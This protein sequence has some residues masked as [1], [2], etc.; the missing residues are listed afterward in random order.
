MAHAISWF[1]IPVVDFDRAKTFYETILGVSLETTEMANDLMGFFPAER[2]DVSGA[3]VK[4]EGLTPGSDGVLIYLNGG[5]D[6][7]SIL[8]RV[9]GAGGTVLMP[10]TCITEEIGYMAQFRDVEGNRVALHSRG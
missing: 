3:I 4:G 6:L 9:E 2:G 10:K 5:D 7:N 8:S 1:E